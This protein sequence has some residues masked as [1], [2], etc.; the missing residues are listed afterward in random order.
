LAGRL[1][2]LEIHAWYVAITQVFAHC[3]V[4]VSKE[5]HMTNLANPEA[6]HSELIA[7][8]ERQCEIIADLLMK[9]ELLRNRL[10]RVD[11]SAQSVNAQ[12][13]ELH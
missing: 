1:F 12:C 13:N 7:K 6:P 11:N 2:L 10:G 9:N 4:R 5:V 8:I 3:G